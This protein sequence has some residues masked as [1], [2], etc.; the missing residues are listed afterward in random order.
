MAWHGIWP[1]C[2]VWC[3]AEVFAQRLAAAC[4]ELVD[5]ELIATIHVPSQAVLFL[6]VYDAG[7]AFAV[8]GPCGPWCAAGI[9]G[10]A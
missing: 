2:N 7:C 6:H 3:S 8:Q 10:H 4:I 9:A 5:A 1:S